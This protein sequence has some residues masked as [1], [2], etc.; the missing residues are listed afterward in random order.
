M[1]DD[2]TINVLQ[3]AMRGLS[4]RQQAI[5]QD[6]ANVNTPYYRA[7][8]VTFEGALKSALENGE[9][10]LTVQPQVAYSQTEGNGLTGNNV[11]LDAETVASVQ[12]EMSFELATRA[13]SDRFTLYKTAIGS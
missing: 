1:L 3:A 4:S 2:V 8:N 12:T 10:P 6:I 13:A 7:R 11:D 5:S 9:N